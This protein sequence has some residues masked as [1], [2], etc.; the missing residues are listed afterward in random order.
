M[1]PESENFEQLRRLLA[2]K[3]YEQPPPGYFKDF[4]QQVIMH[5]RA[6]GPEAEAVGTERLIWE[7]PWLQRFWAALEHN[8]ILAGGF[9]VIV[10]AL[11]VSGVIFSENMAGSPDAS[12][13]SQGTDQPGS[14]A[15]AVA[16]ASAI[17]H[18]L[19]TQPAGVDFSSTFG[20]QPV[21]ALNRRVSET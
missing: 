20:A 11:L 8:P 12:A 4:S 5:I 14:Q 9:G 15:S 1:N 3:K 21:A 6:A 13:L 7:A 2:I 17:S 10:C 19:L 16:D 18:P